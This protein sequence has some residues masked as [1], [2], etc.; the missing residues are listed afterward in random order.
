VRP[1]RPPKRP[2]HALDEGGIARLLD[3][4]RRSPHYALY[5][6]AVYTGMR[7]SELL[8]PAPTGASRTASAIGKCYPR[9]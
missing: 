5:H 2:V 4:A 3:A 1:P 9:W 7:R 6:T 8:A